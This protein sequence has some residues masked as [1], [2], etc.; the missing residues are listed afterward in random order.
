MIDLVG[1]DLCCSFWMYFNYLYFVSSDFQI[2]CLFSCY[3][4]TYLFNENDCD[5][6]LI[7]IVIGCKLGGV[8]VLLP[9]ALQIFW[10]AIDFHDLLQMS[11]DLD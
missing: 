4:D 3:F 7:D 2:C 9:H 11:I 1:L 10:G 6:V 8:Q 5:W